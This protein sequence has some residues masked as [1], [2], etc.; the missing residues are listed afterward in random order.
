MMKVK[1]NLDLILRWQIRGVDSITKKK[2][3]DIKISGVRNLSGYTQR[4]LGIQGGVISGPARIALLT[5][6]SY[7]G[8]PIVF[9]P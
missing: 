9:S 7:L 6:G 5:V 2:E 4:R 3:E 8:S 1:R